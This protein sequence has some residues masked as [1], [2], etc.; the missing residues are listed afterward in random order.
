MRYSEK[1]FLISGQGNGKD[2]VYH[3]INNT[4]GDGVLETG[5]F[6]LRPT[7]EKLAFECLKTFFEGLSPD[8]ERWDE[9]HFLVERLALLWGTDE[10]E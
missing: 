2:D 7:K 3:V 4:V 6:V 8:D 5:C 9:L 10:F 1:Y